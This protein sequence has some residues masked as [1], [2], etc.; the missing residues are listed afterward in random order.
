[1]AADQGA[2]AL[3]R[4]IKVSAEALQQMLPTIFTVAG[5]RETQ[6]EPATQSATAWQSPEPT[7]GYF[8]DRMRYQARIRW[9]QSPKVIDECMIAVS[10]FNEMQGAFVLD[11]NRTKIL[12]EVVASQVQNYLNQKITRDE[13]APPL[14]PVVAPGKTFGRPFTG[15]LRDYS[16]CAEESELGE[17]KSGTLPLGTYWFGFDIRP[18]GH[19]APLY[20]SAFRNTGRMEHNGVLVCAPQ[21][22]GKTKLIIRWARAAI[23]SKE[24]YGVLIIDVKGNLR[25]KL[26]EQKLQ[27]QIYHFSTDPDDG[28]SDRINFLD[29]PK[30]ITAIDTDRIR[31]LATALV[32]SRGFVERGGVD[33]YHYRNEIVWLTAFIHILKLAQYYRQDWFTGKNGQPRN[34]DLADLYDLLTD[35]TEMLRYFTDLS[36]EEPEF[37]KKNPGK[38]LPVRGIRS[39][40]SE[41]A[42]MLDPN[43]FAFGQRVDK[44]SYRSFTIALTTA[45]EPF[46][47]NGTL[48]GRTT[49]SVDGPGRLFDLETVLGDASQP[50]TVILSARQ[51]DL[52]KSE[53][54]LALV[55]KRL[56]W[57]LFNRMSEPAA[58]KRPL[59]LLLDETRR[60]RD[61]DA[62][63]YVTFAREAKAGCVIVYQSLDQVGPREKIMELLE[64]VGTQIY[65][66]SLV[67]NTA[68]YFIEVLPK[69]W[70]P[71]VTSQTVKSQSGETVNINSSHEQVD[72]FSTTDLYRLPAGPYPALIHIN[73]FPRRKPFFTDMEEQE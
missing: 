12:L 25:Q 3:V 22:S 39:W 54:V 7:E 18:K 8:G 70:R 45:L 11:D 58:E 60:I 15:T 72:Y 33:E 52:Q 27:G 64:N 59:L 36:A 37:E 35:E 17:L 13:A 61:F 63:E 69:R 26:E 30:G 31:Q 68:K 57:F 34:V 44:E 53:V 71:V 51:Q 47:R 55:I 49:A 21:N 62:A 24:R 19:G 65:L 2:N 56:Q 28:K 41:I 67:G 38:P 5:F 4:M 23:W 6:I 32:P 73:G 42:I 66:G 20:L 40:F 50:V 10:V 14:D 16:G 46:A 1:M 48:F 9:Q 29:G 43:K